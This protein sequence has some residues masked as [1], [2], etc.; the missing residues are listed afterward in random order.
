MK[1]LRRLHT[2]QG[3]IGFLLFFVLL[4]PFFLVPIYSPRHYRWTGKLNRIW[5]KGTLLFCWLGYRVVVEKPLDPSR[6]YIFCPNHF[7][8]LDIPTMGLNPIDTIFVGKQSMENV[9]VF[10]WMYRKLHITVDR[11]RLRSKY[12]T[13]VRSAE[14]LDEGKSIVIYPEGGIFS[15]YP[16]Q[17]A[18]FKEGPFRLAIEKQIPIVPVTIPNNWIILPPHEFLVRFGIVEVIF[19]EPIET[20][21]MTLADL[22]PLMNQTF[23]V[24]ENEL[25]AH[26]NNPRHPG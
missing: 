21:G 20:S 25:N 13:F 16:P 15:P 9:P 11:S 19:H 23:A 12:S 17:L 10:G 8:Y 3:L 14:A 24:I 2:L 22:R 18:P 26:G 5:A 4:L 7:S 6:N 1:F